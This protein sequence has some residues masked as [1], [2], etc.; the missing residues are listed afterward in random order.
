MPW[1][2]DTSSLKTPEQVNIL[3]TTQNV[4][5]FR[6]IPPERFRG[7]QANIQIDS[8]CLLS[9]RCN[10][11]CE[12][13]KDDDGQWSM[14]MPG[15]GLGRKYTGVSGPIKRAY[16]NPFIVVD[17]SNGTEQKCVEFATNIA[18][19][20]WYRSNGYSRVMKWNELT[21]DDKRNY[22]L[23]IIATQNSLD[24]LLAE[25]LPFKFVTLDDL[26]YTPEAVMTSFRNGYPV[27]GYGLPGIRF[28]GGVCEGMDLSVQFVYP[29]PYNENKLIHVNMAQTEDAL[30]TCSVLTSL[31]SGSSLPDFVLG[32]R[33]GIARWG[34]QG[35]KAIGFFDVNWQFDDSLIY[36]G[37]GTN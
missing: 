23:I 1:L 11:A 19:R 22:N 15:N 7:P 16:F 9:I 20:W 25:K 28:D 5:A 37:E 24:P 6:F 34:M 31:Y 8:N 13:Y 14:Q 33:E 4:K 36:I 12:F 21:E 26:Q 10:D 29:S 35:A 32:N 30:E 27:I 3:F 18:V 2:K 17:M